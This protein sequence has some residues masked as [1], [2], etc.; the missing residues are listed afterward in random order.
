MPFGRNAPGFPDPGAVGGIDPVSER[1][2]SG[3]D[4]GLPL[5]GLEGG[6]PASAGIRG[7]VFLR[8]G[9]QRFRSLR[10]RIPISLIRRGGKK[11]ATCG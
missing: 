5:H 9:R 6:L 7:P 2:E 4:W 1:N 10:A 3:R 11:P 8:V